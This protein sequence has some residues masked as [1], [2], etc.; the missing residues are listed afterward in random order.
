MLGLREQEGLDTTELTL[1][2]VEPQAGAQVHLRLKVLEVAA[3]VVGVIP[4]EPLEMVETDISAAVV[5]AAEESTEVLVA[6]RA[7]TAE[8]AAAA[9]SSSSQSKENQ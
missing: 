2:L 4:T 3:V 7:A 5:A 6:Q 8:T 9:T 1:A